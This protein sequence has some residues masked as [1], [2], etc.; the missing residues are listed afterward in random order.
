MRTYC[1]NSYC[2]LRLG[3]RLPLLLKFLPNC[4]QSGTHIVQFVLLLSPV[5]TVLC[6]SIGFFFF[7]FLSRT[8]SKVHD[9]RCSLV[10]SGVLRK[11]NWSWLIFEELAN[12]FEAFHARNSRKGSVKYFQP[13]RLVYLLHSHF[14]WDNY[15]HIT[16]PDMA[17]KNCIVC[18]V[19][20]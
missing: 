14:Q 12:I 11:M 19:W 16:V 5:V 18:L 10:R 1:P 15:I 3:F 6:V 2:L 13:L 7:F 20:G 4:L 8:C 9:R 17:Y